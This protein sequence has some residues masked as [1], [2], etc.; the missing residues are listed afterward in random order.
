MRSFEIPAI[1]G[2]ML[3]EDTQEHREILGPEGQCVLYFT[4]PAE[5]IEKARW[6]LKNPV[7]R[8]R[9]ARAAHERIITGHNTYKDRLEQMLAAA[10]S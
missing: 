7:E 8:R 4:S 2:F 1:G 10:K 5:A 6:A 9:M 3:A